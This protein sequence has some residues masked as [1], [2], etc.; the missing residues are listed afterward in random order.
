MFDRQTM[1]NH[2]G[3]ISGPD[4]FRNI[5]DYLGLFSPQ[6][7]FDTSCSAEDMLAAVMDTTRPLLP[8]FYERM[9]VELRYHPISTSDDCSLIT[10]LI[11][12]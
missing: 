6:F 10:M 2:E 1:E 7:I 9:K 12:C 5:S 3:L 8:K 4:V 11:V